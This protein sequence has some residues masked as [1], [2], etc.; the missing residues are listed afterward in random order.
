MMRHDESELSFWRLL[1]DRFASKASR[2]VLLPCRCCCCWP[3]ASIL[4]R[5]NVG[6]CWPP[7]VVGSSLICELLAVGAG[8]VALVGAFYKLQ[9]VARRRNRFAPRR[10]GIHK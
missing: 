5:L 10:K 8:E 7:E 2:C 3:A 4:L 6:C 1:A 9:L